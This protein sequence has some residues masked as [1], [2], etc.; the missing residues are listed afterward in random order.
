MVKYRAVRRKKKKQVWQ[1]PYAPLIAIFAAVLVV[2]MVAEY[3][4]ITAVQQKNVGAEAEQ[5]AVAV[6]AVPTQA[7]ATPAPTQTQAVP[8]T[9]PQPSATAEPEPTPTTT[10][11]PDDGP[12]P[13]PVSM[14]KTYTQEDSGE[15][16]RSIQQ[17]LEDLGFDPGE[18][19]GIYGDMLNK[20]IINF[21]MY[22]KLDVDGIAGPGT[23]AALVEKWKDAKTEPDVDDRPLKGVV[24]GIDP[25][26]QR[27]GNDDLE[28]NAP[29]SSTMKKKVS[30]GT[31]GRFTGVPEYVINLQVG[32]RL[33]RELEALGA[34]V[35]MAREV[36][37]VN[38]S[39]A[40]RAEMMN[41]ADVDCWLR[42]H[43]NGS[44]D[45]SVD[46]MFILVPEPGT[47]DTDEPSI[48][49]ESRALA[50]V[51]VKTTQE[52]T[53]ASLA[54]SHGISVRDDQTGFCWSRVPVCNIEMGHMTNERE[55]RL[56]ITE[57]YQIKIVEGLVA[58]F[59]AYFD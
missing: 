49:Q 45:A 47:M 41:E 21:Q 40:T 24:I 30:S 39:N 32:L 50:E 23:I 11:E 56:L 22:A 6:T 44:N 48:A 25:G 29:G 4:I 12:T 28:P 16:I 19:D 43:A 58:G 54:R 27:H 20:A 35:I 9:T 17:M 14:D 59:V 26:H 2:A 53:G 36:H 42:I 1:G 51:L 31:Y 10:P 57:S 15:E 46:G 13:P 52:A 55:D 5:T 7:A 34:D 8:T 33:Q 3:F 37:G 38:I 18:P